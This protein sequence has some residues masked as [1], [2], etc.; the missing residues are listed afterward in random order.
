MII[1]AGLGNPGMEY[2]RTRH[3]V[4][5]EVVNTLAGRLSA[6][7]RTAGNALVS[8]TNLRGEKL[9]LVKPMTYMNNSGQAVRP[10]MRRFGAEPA[11]LV[12]VY[13]DMDLPAGTLRFRERGSAGGHRGMLSII[14]YLGTSDFCRLRVGI[15]RGGSAAVHVLQKFT[16]AEKEVMKE[17]FGAAADALEDLIAEGP[18]YV[19]NKYN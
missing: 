8:E 9:V 3:N 18:V 5:F 15:G 12:V 17:A 14:E 19:M 11:D 1:I 10:V 2:A 7:F 4:G 16:A 6:R 13:D